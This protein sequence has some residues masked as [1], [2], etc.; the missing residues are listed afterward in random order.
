MAFLLFIYLSILFCSYQLVEYNNGI[1]VIY[2]FIYFILL[3]PTCR[4]HFWIENRTIVYRDMATFVNQ[5]QILH[6]GKPLKT[7]FR[8]YMYIKSKKFFVFLF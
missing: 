6:T 7:T 4:F 2:L 3:L 1:S 5:V 8:L